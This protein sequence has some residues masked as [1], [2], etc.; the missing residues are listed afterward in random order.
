MLP[1]VCTPVHRPGRLTG[2]LE[3]G[4]HLL[5][6]FLF[7]VLFLRAQASSVLASAPALLP[8]P[9]SASTSEAYFSEKVRPLLET[10]CYPCHS[11]DA[12]KMRGGLT[13]D[14]RSG[15]SQGGDSGP[16][17]V[18]GDPDHSLLIRAVRRVNSVAP[19]P[20]KKPLTTQEIQTLVTWVANGAHDPRVSNASS[21]PPPTN[22]ESQTWWAVQP[23]TLPQPPPSSLAHPIDAFT[24]PQPP[25]PSTAPSQPTQADRRTLLRRLTVQLHGLLPT[26]EAVAE[27]VAD[28]DPFALN[29]QI[30]RLLNSPRYGERWARHWLDVVHFAESHGHDQDSPRDHAWPYRDYVIE[31]F[32]SDTPYPRFVQEQIAADA[33]FPQ[34]P[35]LIPALGF[36]AA[37]PWDE[38]SLRDIREDTLDRDIGRYLDRDDIVANVFS[39]FASVTVHCARCHD[40]KFDPVPQADYFALQAVFA[41]TEKAERLFDPDPEIH[42]Q[43]EGWMRL[44]VAIERQDRSLLFENLS[45]QL[46]QDQIT[47]EETITTPTSWTTLTTVSVH[48][49]NNTTLTLQ[50]DGSYL[51]SGESPD[52]NT[53][54]LVVAPP[55]GTPITAIR[56]EVLPH[57]SLPARGPGRAPNGNLHLTGFEVHSVSMAETTAAVD[58]DTA[59]VTH[60]DSVKRERII[61]LQTPS[62]DF[63]QE[64]WNITQA[65]DGKPESGWGI[66]PQEGRPHEA[67]FE[68][69]ASQQPVPET[70]WQIVLRQDH[71]RQHTLGRFRLSVTSQPPPV[72]AAGLPAP[73]A[74]ALATPRDQRTAEERWTLTR[75]YLQQRIPREWA[76]LPEPRR[77]F[78]GAHLYPANGGQKPLGRPRPIHLL[79]RGEITQPLNEA[80]PGALRCLSTLPHQFATEPNEAS[81]RA[82]LA[83]WLTHPDNPLL[84]RSIVNRVWHYHF[85]RGLVDTPNDFGRMGG[86]PTHPDLLDWLAVTF[87]D[88]LQ[89]SLKSLHRLILTSRTWQ[90]TATSPSTATPLQPLRRRLDAE[91]FRDSVLQAAGHLDLAMGGPSV[92][93]FVLSPGIHV[94]PNVDYDAF[95]MDHP[96]MAR[97]SIYRFLFRTLPDPLMDTLDS[98][99]GDQSAPVR[100]ES[101]TA[102]QAF[103]LLHHP[104]VVRFSEHLAH[105]VDTECPSPVQRIDRTYQ[106]LFQRDPDPAEAAD[107]LTHVARH[108]LASLCRLLL[109]SNELHFLP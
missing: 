27:F 66:H 42:A 30:D 87:R 100:N 22:S 43:R 106:L 84:W 39:T 65:L 47:W 91:T 24:F 36:L 68:F 3:I 48:A 72:S 57:D 95:D 105:R 55:P 54:S 109:N 88:D 23:L 26:P 85:G 93:H 63:N 74:L 62:A 89:G 8:A 19:M 16:A 29:H 103:A 10:H 32:N 83:R 37:G 96:D 82:A 77:V 61:G 108:G 102:L 4:H 71:G 78:A 76:A 33:L 81:R 104:F 15:W 79:R 2:W 41:G 12:G 53:Y 34:Q 17:I 35:Q 44:Q 56:L 11:H 1:P 18:P 58:S 9:A 7:L 5:F 46:Q 59:S 60:P 25:A 97:R 52:S 38:S 69:A 67:V 101:F 45:P 75:H 51:A 40:H 94:T 80:T 99:P 86:T 49:R 107:A 28:P 92:R 6:L 14:S 21:A 98:P 70:R 73:V 13:L 20:P 64:G 50:D 31:A 90:Q